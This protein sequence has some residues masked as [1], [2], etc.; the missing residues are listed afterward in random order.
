M[1]ETEYLLSS[2]NNAKRLRESIEQLKTGKVVIR[3]LKSGKRIGIAKDLFEVQDTI[4]KHNDE[5]AQLFN[6]EVKS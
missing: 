6:G 4:D 1:N 3:E 2:E 5:V